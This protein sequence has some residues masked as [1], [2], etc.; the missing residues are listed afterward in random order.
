MKETIQAYLIFDNDTIASQVCSFVETE[1]RR[2]P[3]WENS[4]NKIFFGKG[5]TRD[6]KPFVNVIVRFENAL[7][8]SNVLTKYREK[9]ILIKDNI[10]AGSKITK[11]LCSHDEEQSTPCEATIVW[12]KI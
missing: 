12:E 11:H 5:S 3:F 10:L 4:N 2:Y 8:H 6:G 7:D 9:A 1:A